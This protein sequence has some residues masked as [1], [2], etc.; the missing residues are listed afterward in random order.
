M[1]IVR[2]LPFFYDYFPI[3]SMASWTSASDLGSKALVASSRT[4]ILGSL[5]KAL[6]IA[7]LYF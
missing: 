3:L 2:L 7:I 1:M 5:I 4:K 6:A